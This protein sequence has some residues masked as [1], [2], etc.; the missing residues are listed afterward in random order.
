M[1]KYLNLRNGSPA[2]ALKTM[3]VLLSLKG[4][5]FKNYQVVSMKFKLPK[6]TFN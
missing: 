6:S 1:F 5:S 3:T 2:E 4:P